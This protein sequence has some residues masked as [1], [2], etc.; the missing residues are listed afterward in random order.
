M[1]SCTNVTACG[2]DI[3]G[4]WTVAGSCLPVTGAVDVSGF[5]LGCSEAP[6]TGSLQVAGTWTAM[7]DGTYVDDTTTTGEQVFAMPASCLNVSG[8]VTS[9]DR[10]ARPF[11]STLGFTVVTCLSDTATGGCTCTATVEQLGGMGVISLEKPKSGTYTATGN[12]ITATSAESETKYDYCV[13]GSTM[14]L[15]VASLPKPGKV[16]GTIVFQKP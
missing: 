13:T 10:V 1:A 8:T 11:R 12:V 3:V 2:G 7:A 16:S 14:T 6:V 15:S 5:G 4:A 9:C